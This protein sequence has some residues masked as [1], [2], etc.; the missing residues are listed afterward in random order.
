[1][2]PIVNDDAEISCSNQ[3]I[4]YTRITLTSVKDRDIVSQILLECVVVRQPKYFTSRCE[5]LTPHVQRVAILYS[6]F[7]HPNRPISEGGKES[8]VY[9]VI[10]MVVGLVTS[11][12]LQK[13]RKTRFRCARWCARCSSRLGEERDGGREHAHRVQGHGTFPVLTRTMVCNRSS[14]TRGR[15]APET[16]NACARG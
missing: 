5:V 9:D 13:A 14:R 4:E 2:R 15:G 12:P 6:N 8:L 7:E 16:S 3:S 10:R 11:R 1:M